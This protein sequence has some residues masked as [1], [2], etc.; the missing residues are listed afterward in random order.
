MEKKT[1][2]EIY[3]LL[4]KDIK[5]YVKGLNTEDN[6]VYKSN[7]LLILS[8]FNKALEIIEEN[9]PAMQTLVKQQQ[10]IAVDKA[11]EMCSSLSKEMIYDRDN[12]TKE[13]SK[14]LIL[15]NFQVCYATSK[16][17]ILSLKTEILKELKK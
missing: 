9:I 11:L 6:E 1:A 12:L 16:Q 13:E 17:E 14:G 15:R 3:N 2:E 7:E 5:I 8:C 4:S 10:E